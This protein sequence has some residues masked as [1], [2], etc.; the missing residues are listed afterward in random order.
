MGISLYGLFWK[1]RRYGGKFVDYLS[2]F[3][4]RESYSYGEWQNY[5]EENLRK[6]LI[7]VNK[8][9][10]YYQNLF[11]VSGITQK[12]LLRFALDDLPNLP[13]LTKAILRD[14]PNE[15]TSKDLREKPN[16]YLTSGTTGTPLAIKFTKDGDRMAQAAYEIRVRNWA[17][18]NYK[19]SR[20]MIGGRMIVPKAYAK[21]PFWRYNIFESQLY[22]SAFHISP[23]NAPDY[24]RAL[25][26]Y[27]PDYLVG[28]ASS[29][30]FLARMLDEQSIEMYQP[31][32]VLTSSEKL[33]PEMR[34]TIEKVYHCIELLDENNDPV[35]PGTPGRIVATG[36]VNFA[37]P[38]IRYDT[39]DVAVLSEESCPCGRQMPVIQEIIGRIEDTVI[40][41][42]GKE[43]VRF[44]GIFTGLKSVKEGQVIQEDYDQFRVK[45]T[46]DK[47]FDDE[48]KRKICHRF[49]QRLGPIH[50][51]FEIVDKI[52]R[53]NQGKFKA[54]ISHV[55]R[56]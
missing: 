4:R 31:K 5:Q 23:A 13:L 32:A 6:L 20:A 45:L 8:N 15:F 52:E 55:A 50:L 53:T 25:N 39:G 35:P 7:Y 26:H 51:E 24:A 33:T 19:M 41:K 3:K 17:G 46:V 36:L 56:K 44:H 2:Q 47:C 16:T 48:D 40:T 49:H 30:Y 1:N 9:V 37:Q 14:K 12:D 34:S 38:L 28:Y 10:P 29:Y 11:E 22:M 54:V 43:T 27:K 18:V 21:P 42:D